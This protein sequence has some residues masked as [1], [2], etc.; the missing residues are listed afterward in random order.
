MVIVFGFLLLAI[1]RATS[2]KSEGV[3]IVSYAV[4]GICAQFVVG[5]A[6]AGI[7]AMAHKPKSKPAKPTK[8]AQVARSGRGRSLALS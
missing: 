2:S 5:A 4:T 8:S 7:H 3:R 6:G 1:D